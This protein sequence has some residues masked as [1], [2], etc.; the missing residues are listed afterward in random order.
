MCLVQTNVHVLCLIMLDDLTEFNIR[1]L[2]RL[3]PDLGLDREVVQE[4]IGPV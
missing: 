2:R 4:N 3:Y 1:S